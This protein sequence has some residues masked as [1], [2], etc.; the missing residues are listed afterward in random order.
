MRVSYP[1][2]VYRYIRRVSFS[3]ADGYQAIDK[4]AHV[5]DK[6]AEMV[7]LNETMHG[8]ALAS[9]LKGT[10]SASGAYEVDALLANVCKL[11]VT[12]LPFE[13]AR[14]AQDIAGGILVTMPSLADREHRQ[15][16]EYVKKY[17]AGKDDGAS[18]LRMRLVRLIENITLGPGAAS[19]LTESVHGAGSPQ[20]QKIMI[21][22]LA[23]LGAK[24]ACALRLC[25]AR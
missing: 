21:G 24:K 15:V 13:I 9:A 6:L 17:F 14:L 12:R 18:D 1:G 20:A 25:G 11:N 3:V 10:A 4:T 23:D 5:R 2:G 19:Y 8:V 16:G 7:H 22:R